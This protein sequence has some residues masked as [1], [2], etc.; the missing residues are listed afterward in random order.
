[1]GVFIVRCVE[2]L[3]ALPETFWLVALV[4]AGLAV[5]SYLVR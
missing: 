1:M 5:G 4:M 2:G 3:M